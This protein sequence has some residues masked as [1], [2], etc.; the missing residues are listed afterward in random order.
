MLQ[1]I[2]AQPN[3][4][5]GGPRLPPPPEKPAP[6]VPATERC[7]RSARAPIGAQ[8]VSPRM[9]IFQDD[10][11]AA[12]SFQSAAQLCGLLRRRKGTDKSPV[13]GARGAEIGAANDRLAVA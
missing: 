5:S 8:S 12:C 7:P 9:S 1:G 4:M 13:V 6:F 10:A 11:I 2:G 3:A